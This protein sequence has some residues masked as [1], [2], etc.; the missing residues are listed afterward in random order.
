VGPDLKYVDEQ[1]GRH[2]ISSMC[3]LS[4]PVVQRTRNNMNCLL[5]IILTAVK[6]VGECVNMNCVSANEVI[7]FS[8]PYSVI[9]LFIV[10]PEGA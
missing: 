6:Y 8:Y 10:P 5:F 1:M 9:S 3:F 4:M 7:K 2:A